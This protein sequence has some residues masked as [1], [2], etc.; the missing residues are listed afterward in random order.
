MQAYISCV[1]GENRA[2]VTARS[3]DADTL[4]RQISQLGISIKS[5]GLRGRY[6]HHRHMKAVQQIQ[7][8][9][10]RDERFRLTSCNSLK[11]P[12]RATFNGEVVKDRLLHEVVLESILVRRCD[13]W[14]TVKAVIAARADQR[15][16]VLTV[17]PHRYDSR[18]TTTTSN[19]SFSNTQTPYDSDRGDHKTTP[20]E[21][22]KR[23]IDCSSSP[24]DSELLSDSTRSSAELI[25]PKDSDSTPSYANTPQPSVTKSPQDVKE[26]ASQATIAVIGMAC[27]FPKARSIDE[28]WHLINSGTCAVESVP[29]D[30]FNVAELPRNPKG[31]F[32]GN[33]I[34]DP[35]AFDH[36]FFG[37][38]AREAK[39]V[40]PQQ[41]IL[42]EVAYE[43]MQSA[44]YFTAREE[45]RNNVVGCYVGVGSVDYET[46]VASEHATAFSATGTL[47]AFIS[48]K[49]SHYFG[50]TGPSITFDTACSS[51]AV[52]LHSAIR[53]SLFSD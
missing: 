20:T 2:T 21:L 5:L 38:T 37:M 29:E 26:N 12:L 19:I 3:R 11:L 14:K 34:Q 27:R 30:R 52:G 22:E 47:R 41:R 39:S 16:R 9:C 10:E 25:T 7:Q 6:H 24:D 28:F 46:N 23:D 35:D 49:V 40:D 50:W 36:R 15:P 44:G 8:L 1:T 33:F 4:A 48:G 45:E 32:W 43:A 31:P 13:W 18:A 51:S 53:V 42:L 17:G